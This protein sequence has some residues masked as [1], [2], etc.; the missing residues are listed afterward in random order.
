[1]IGKHNSRYFQASRKFIFSKRLNVIILG[2][3]L[4]ENKNKTAI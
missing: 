4:L 2:K 3:I 1:M